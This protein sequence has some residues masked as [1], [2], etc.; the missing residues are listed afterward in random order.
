MKI[1][2]N[3]GV[4]NLIVLVIIRSKIQLFLQYF[5]EVK[6]ELDAII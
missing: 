2:Q 4:G 1:V 6:F 5:R 3:S